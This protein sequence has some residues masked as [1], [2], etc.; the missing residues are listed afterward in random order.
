M[1]TLALVGPPD[2]QLEA[3]VRSYVR[4]V[5]PLDAV[6]LAEL[7]G[8]AGRHF[9]AIVVDLRTATSIPAAISAIRRNHPTVGVIII[10]AALDPAFLVEA[11]RA[12][13]N[14]VVTDPIDEAELERA[15]ARVAEQ[16]PAGEL[17]DVFGFVGAKGGVGATTLAVNVAAVLGSVSKPGRT[18]LIDLHPAGGDAAVF[19]GIEPRFSIME[20]FENTHRLDH[21]FLNSLVIQA[22]PN[23][24]LLASPDRGGVAQVD[25]A[26]I[27]TVI[28]F[29]A[30]AY[31]FIVLDLPRADAAVLDSLECLKRLVVVANQELAT[32]KSARRMAAVLRRRY[33]G[34]KVSIVLSRTD[35]HA[36]IAHEDVERAVGSE[37]TH[38]FP[39]DYRVAL[40]ALN[41]GRPLALENHSELSGSFKKFALQLA[42]VRPEPAAA[43]RT[44]LLGRLTQRA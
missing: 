9:H 19:L 12:G 35:R 21:T 13:V 20:A 3:L 22:A 28:E 6:H 32:V 15:L 23:L 2:R 7:A 1:T 8:Q 4:Q 31:R 39:S 33:S 41:K 17:G 14:E 5:T 29:A 40:Q 16:R 43:P 34:D 30:T 10:T 24:D 42:V 36:E 25:A 44:G 18:L 26:K 38:V 11:M 37:L 27:R